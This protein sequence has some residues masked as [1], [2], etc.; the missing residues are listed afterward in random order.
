MKNNKNL[1]LIII[2]LMVPLSLILGMLLFNEIEKLQNVYFYDFE[3]D[4]LGTFPDGFVGVGRNVSLTSVVYFDEIHSKV[5]EVRY[6]IPM[7][8]ESIWIIYPGVE[9][10]TL[11]QL[12]KVGVIE[13]D[14]NMLYYKRMCIDICQSDVGYDPIDDIRIWI[15]YSTGGR[16]I[17]IINENGGRQYLCDFLTQTWYH[18]KIEFDI[19]VGWNI[20]IDNKLYKEDI[21]WQQ[22]PSYFC[23]LYFATYELGQVFS[24][25]NVRITMLEII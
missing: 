10:N 3:D 16:D 19:D 9:L 17:S 21:K 18:F 14:I 20:W 25:D 4:K 22:R 7:D 13:F 1:T 11:F 8:L 12:T 5:V 24:I 15:G 6:L 23:Q 2:A